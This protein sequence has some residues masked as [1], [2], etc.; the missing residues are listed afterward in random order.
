MLSVFVHVSSVAAGIIE[1]LLALSPCMGVMR[2]T[3]G[4]DGWDRRSGRVEATGELG[5]YQG[6]GR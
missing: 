2:S 6:G 3:Q 5:E 4:C 1:Y